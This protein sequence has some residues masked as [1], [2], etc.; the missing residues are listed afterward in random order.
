MGQRP[1]L[2]NQAA[3]TLQLCLETLR[4][5]AIARLKKKLEQCLER[6]TQDRTTACLASAAAAGAVCFYV[7]WRVGLR[8]G[9]KP[10]LSTRLSSVSLAE[11]IQKRENGFSTH[12]SIAESTASG[13]SG[14]EMDA[15]SQE[16]FGLALVVR[17]DL[18]MVRGKIASQ[19]CRAF[20]GE[21]KKLQQ[22]DYDSLVAWERDG[23]TIV[24]H[25]VES[26]EAIVQLR[27]SAK[28]AGITSHTMLDRSSNHKT[29]MAIGPARL[30]KL[31]Q[32]TGHLKLL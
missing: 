29:A 32:L 28:Q 3:S 2:F 31:Q 11:P 19:C 14:S 25:Q 9:K 1:K 22:R 20:W 16:H 7:G 4:I 8:R 24:V 12:R 21:A 5:L 17:S 10:T 26:E 13:V 6:L 23:H 30:D 15:E 18:G 27:K